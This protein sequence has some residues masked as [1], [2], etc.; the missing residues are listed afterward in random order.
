MEQR[1][2]RGT[3]VCPSFNYSLGTQPVPACSNKVHF[4]AAAH[5][6]EKTIFSKPT[7]FFKNIFLEE[8]R[9]SCQHALKETLFLLWRTVGSLG[10]SANGMDC[11]L[12]L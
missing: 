8:K 12:L 3:A 4:K 2:Q 9:P 7:S 5:Y 10:Q 6:T 1:H 11:K